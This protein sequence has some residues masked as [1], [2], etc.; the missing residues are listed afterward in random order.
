M[1]LSAP[2]RSLIPSLDSAVLEVLARTEEPQSA[3]A[4]W[5]ASA[6]GTRSGQLPV[7][8]RLV[9]H[10]LVTASP[11]ATGNLY[12][13]NREHILADA[14]LSASRAR[15]RIVEGLRDELEQLNPRPLH[16]FVFGSFARGEADEVSDIDL[17]IVGPDSVDPRS[18]DWMRQT[19]ALAQ[20]VK[21]WTGNDLQALTFTETAFMNL[22]AADEPIVRN[23]R[24]DAIRVV[25]DDPF[26][27][28]ERLQN[29]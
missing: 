28:L 10:G 14:V 25:G 22:A 23:W 16:A 11:A 24:E 3:S 6:R 15:V 17:A 9:E 12:A 26:T 2:L 1:D 8:A 27:F 21:R 20:A 18:L 4:I 13:L 5:R 19:D 29:R 7:I